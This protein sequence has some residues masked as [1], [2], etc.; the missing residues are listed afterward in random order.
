MVGVS[1][2]LALQAR[3][4]QVTLIDAMAPGRQTSFGNAGVISRGSVVPP[5]TPAIW[6]NLHRFAG[7]RHPAVRYSAGHLARHG[8]W[9]Y[10]FLRAATAR[11][12]AVT[13]EAL[14]SLVA[15]AVD[16]HAELMRDAA[17]EHRLRRTGWLKLFRGERSL[18]A[19]GVERA[20]YD[21]FGIGYRVL[22]GA[23]IAEVEPHLAPIFTAGVLVE[24]SASVD[25]PGAVV[26]AYADLFAARGGTILTAGIDE[27]LADHRR[28]PAVR[29]SD[30]RTIEGDDVVVALGPWSAEVL[31]R[32]GVRMPLGYER[33]YHRHYA[34]DGNSRIARPIHDVD[35]H[36]VVT[37]MERGI[38][39][40]TGI[41]LADRDAPANPAQSQAVEPL[42]RQALAV[43]PPVEGGDWHGSRPSLPD[44]R[45]AIGAAPGLARVWC[46]F[47]HGHIGFSTG[48]I[49]GELVAQM[50]VGEPPSIDVVP[51]DPGRF[52]RRR[53]RFG[54][55][56]N[57]L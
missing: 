17:I 14:N 47:G 46:A 21:R 50:I 40:T 36:Y 19:F 34:P 28:R 52:A 48:P 16:R 54:V 37:P 33:G 5:N 3:G 45:P 38:R 41:E 9:T 32:P 13:A 42:M 26:A 51:F 24:D 30:G 6:R 2:A 35:G 20:F 1:A 4:R 31:A 49:S 55:A 44:G 29:L 22:R 57:M 39:V 12:V 11:R 27:L 10:G 53:R 25:D 18:A 8:R 23:Q 43:G 56:S 7:N 15:D